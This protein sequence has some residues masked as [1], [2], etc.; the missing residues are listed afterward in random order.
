MLVF[1]NQKPIP[2]RKEGEMSEIYLH[3]QRG[4]AYLSFSSYISNL[5]LSEVDNRGGANSR[6][7]FSSKDY[8]KKI[9]I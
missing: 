1:S 7:S 6:L 3:Q 8:L 9:I 4:R 5:A 2:R